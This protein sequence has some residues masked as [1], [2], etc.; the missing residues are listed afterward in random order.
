MGT[1][2]KA[3]DVTFNRFVAIK[4]LRSLPREGV[5]Q[6][7]AHEGAAARLRHPNILRILDV[8]EAS[9]CAYVAMDFIEGRS[10]AEILREGKPLETHV[11]IALVADVAAAL[12]FAHQSGVIHRDVKPTN[13]LVS[14]S[15]QVL[16]TDFGL[17]AKVGAGTLTPWGTVLGTPAYMSP[18]QAM[19]LP[20]DGRSDVYSLAVVLYEALS[21]HL[22]TPRIVSPRRTAQAGGGSTVAVG[23]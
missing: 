8:G 19:G 21:G 9:G 14:N 20:L 23:T 16:L 2:Y 13:I 4:T 22:W 11:A 6:L 12:S 17:A 15:G 5:Q 10:L 18:E 7:A 1:V 3:L